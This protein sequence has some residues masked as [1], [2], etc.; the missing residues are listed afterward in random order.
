MGKK[1]PE[2]DYLWRWQ[3][4]IVD[5]TEEHMELSYGDAGVHK[6]EEFVLV[7]LLSA[8]SKNVFTVQF[9]I[10]EGDEKTKTIVQDVKQELNLYL[11][12]L[13]ETNPW[14]YAKYHCSTASN[15]YSKV[16]WRYHS[17]GGPMGY[18]PDPKKVCTSYVERN[19]LTIRRQI[20]RFT[21]LAYAFSKKLVNLKAAV[22][23]WFCYYNFCRIH[24]SLR[25]MPGMEVGLT[26]SVWGVN[27]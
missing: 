12:E 19:N 11:I 24:G 21:R 4:G 8:P 26:N 5:R 18:S 27:D 7:A 22:P 14:A 2:Q 3:D 20:R 10:K 13:Q 25:I 16:H 15:I 17:K 1:L 9:L 6:P 23:L